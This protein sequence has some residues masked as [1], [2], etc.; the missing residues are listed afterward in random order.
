MLD[1][2]D[3]RELFIYLA[4]DARKAQEHDLFLFE[5]Q[6]CFGNEFSVIACVQRAAVIEIAYQA[7]VAVAVV[8]GPAPHQGYLFQ[9]LRL[10]PVS[11]THLTLPTNIIRCRWRWWGWE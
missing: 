1:L 7:G 4:K 11:Y 3:C 2:F 8:D 5:G 9:L 10:T 6:L